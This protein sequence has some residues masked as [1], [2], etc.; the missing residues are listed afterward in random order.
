MKKI[1][2][3]VGMVAIGASA[4]QTASAQVMADN[5]KPWSISATLRG[6]YDDNT[7]TVPNNQGL[8]PGEHRASTGFEISP[9]GTLVWSPDAATA[10]NLGMLYAYKY[11]DHPV[12]S[13]TGHGD[14]TFTFSGDLKHAFNERVQARA[15]DSFVIGQ[16]PD[17]LRAGNTFATYQRVS[18]NNI[19][20]YGSLGLDDQLTPKF[21]MSFGY[22]NAFYN[23]KDSGVS[24]NANQIVPSSAGT[25]NRDE[26]RAHLEGLYSLMPETKGILGYQFSQVNYLADEYVTGDV[27]NPSSLVKSDFRNSRENTLY[28]GVE[29]NFSPQLSAALRAGASYTD[30]FNDSSADSVWSPYVNGSVKY[31]YASQSSLSGGVVFD[32][33]PTDVAGGPLGGTTLDAEAVTVFIAVSHAITPQVFANVI[34]QFQNSTYNGGAFDNK[35]EQYYLAGLNLEYRFNQYFSAHVGYNYDNLQSQLGRAYDR[36][37]IYVGVTGTY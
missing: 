9:S 21:G 3:S 2:A 19:R 30:Y 26:N 29:H 4:I 18:G 31:A 16:E 22:D 24:T 32:R 14:N 10:I 11:Y 34:A 7:G 17:L 6:F 1:V 33:T 5:S 37:R 36:N 28:A 20:N 15:S 8:P 25:L 12:P 27:T 35:N 13:S 23:Y